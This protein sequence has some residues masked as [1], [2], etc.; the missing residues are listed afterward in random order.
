MNKNTKKTMK[1]QSQNVKCSFSCHKL[2]QYAGLSPI[3]RFM[4]K[5]DIGKAL[6]ELFPTVQHNE[7]EH[8]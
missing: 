7:K 1:F 4:K 3:M 5:H 6:D 8:N 2:T